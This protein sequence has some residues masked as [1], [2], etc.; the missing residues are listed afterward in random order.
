MTSAKRSRASW[1]GWQREIELLQKALEQTRHDPVAFARAFL[2][3]EPHPGQIRLLEA[4]GE[5]TRVIH[6]GRR[7]GKT[8]A[9]AVET[10]WFAL[11]HPGSRQLIASVS[12]D[13]ARLMFDRILEFIQA[14]PILMAVTNWKKV[15]FAPFPELE[16][17]TGARVEVRS[18][19]RGGQYV[20]GRK[21]HRA[22]VDEA[23][24]IVDEVIDSA[25]RLTLA[26]TGGQL[27]LA[28]TPRRIGSTMWREWRRLRGTPADVGGSSFE[29]PH[30]DREYLEMM[31][32][33]LTRAQ[34]AR[35][36]LGEWA[37]EDGVFR[38]EDIRRAYEGADWEIPE[39]P[40]RG[41]RYAAGWDLAKHEDWTVGIVLDATTEPYR[42]VRF[43]RFQRAPWP[44]V[45][46][47]IRAVALEYNAETLIDA[48][49]VG[50]AVLD[51]VR[52]VARGFVF[53]AKGKADLLS[54]LQVALERGRIRFP[55][56]RELVDE[57]HSYQ[58]QDKGL[59]TDCVMALALAL[60]AAERGTA[61][62]VPGP[63]A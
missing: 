19:A 2:E 49:G 4:F 36:V 61:V 52:D 17:L 20:R 31:R 35:E 54:A 44:A 60:R 22:V 24:Y 55:F 15:K 34:F 10:L 14:S 6:C 9:L 59:M 48:T 21:Y 51:E 32:E 50:D 25:I 29:N 63:Y 28:S 39:P 12:I 53:T 27:I 42:L 13:Q 46:A 30:V 58:W 26:D 37:D 8:E 41:R 33:R 5:R 3:W 43:E 62:V 47:R 56:I 1:N 40:K 23:E 38:F 7:W 18:T 57:L 16:L 11:F 45:A